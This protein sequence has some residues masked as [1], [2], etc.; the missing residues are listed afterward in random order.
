MK[1]KKTHYHFFS[2]YPPLSGMHRH[3]PPKL[4]P[5]AV[6]EKP[7]VRHKNSIAAL[8]KADSVGCYGSEFDVWLTDD[9]Q[10]GGE[11][12]QCFQRSKYARI[13]R[14]RVYSYRIG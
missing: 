3:N 5:T 10:P 8:M 7:M 11:L 14:Q 12:E 9:D 2:Y 13:N 6:F 4:L 1:L